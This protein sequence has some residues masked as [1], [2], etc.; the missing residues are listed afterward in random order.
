MLKGVIA[1]TVL[2][3]VAIGTLVGWNGGAVIDSAKDKITE[4]SSQLNIFKANENKLVKKLNTVNAEIALLEMDKEELEAKV[5]ELLEAGGDQ[6]TLI[7]D[8]KAQ[9]ASKTNEITSLTAER[10][11]L[12]AEDD[13]S[14]ADGE[15]LGA[16]AQRLQAQLNQANTDAAAL[17]EALDTA[18]T[19][20]VDQEAVDN[21]LAGVIT[22]TGTTPPIEVVNPTG[23]TQVTD[24][25]NIKMKTGLPVFLTAKMSLDVQNGQVVIINKGLAASVV[26]N[27]ATIKLPAGDTGDTITAIG[28]PADLDKHNLTLIEKSG[29]ETYFYLTNN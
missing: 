10:D 15:A 4:Q 12:Q 19:V 28:A 1:T 18:E 21:A 5:A 3:T 20:T 25:A 16:E 6:I 11:A 7:N 27:G 2:G 17:Q 29:T 26:V 9:V 14:Q 8:L 13:S 23:E 22:D 24:S